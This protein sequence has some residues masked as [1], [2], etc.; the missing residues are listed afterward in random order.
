MYTSEA[1][2][3]VPTR[4]VIGIPE[5]PFKGKRGASTTSISAKNEYITVRKVART[6]ANHLGQRNSRIRRFVRAPRGESKIR[7]R[8]INITKRRNCNRAFLLTGEN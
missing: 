5:S 2:L 7:Q 8:K 4:G 6:L 3:E 1:R